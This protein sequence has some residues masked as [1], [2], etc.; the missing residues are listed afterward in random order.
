MFDPDPTTQT[1]SSPTPQRPPRRGSGLG[2]VAGALMLGAVAGGAAGAAAGG[3]LGAGPPLAI[4]SPTAALQSAYKV[5]AANPRT[6]G[7]TTVPRG[8]SGSGP[9]PDDRPTTTKVE[10]LSA[11]ELT[12]RLDTSVR[13]VHTYFPNADD[14]IIG[15]AEWF[16]RQFY[17]TGVQ[18][19]QGPDDLARYFHD[20]HQ[21]TADHLDAILTALEAEGVTFVRL[22]DSAVFP[23]LNQ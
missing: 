17:P 10:I 13:T 11:E 2:I 22:D 23:K 12:Q 5:A 8:G 18:V 1:A 14:Q 3:R 21:N 9:A 20:I 16:D 4:P 15:V 6:S 7:P 19:A